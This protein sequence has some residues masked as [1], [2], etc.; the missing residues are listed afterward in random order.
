M[1]G[2]LLLALSA[3]GTSLD[4]AMLS[5]S[6]AG[7]ECKVVATQPLTA[8]GGA[9]PLRHARAQIEQVLSCGADIAVIDLFDTG[10][11]VDDG[12]SELERSR[13]GGLT[14]PAR[15]HDAL[16]RRK[17]VLADVA[18][19]RAT[20]SLLQ[21]KLAAK[22]FRTVGGSGVDFA[23]I[24]GA[25]GEALAERAPPLDEGAESAESPPQAGGSIEWVSYDDGLRQAAASRKPICLTFVTTWCPHCKKLHKV[26]EDPRVVQ[27]ARSF[28]MVQVDADRSKELADRFSPDGSYVPRT[29]FLSS[30]G[31]LDTSLVASQGGRDRYCYNDVDPR[32][33]LGGMDRALA[34]LGR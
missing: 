5:A 3:P 13:W 9:A 14:P 21:V 7:P 2:L 24:E 19:S 23:T 17:T 29:F 22:G 15:L 34:K 8:E 31:R 18:G 16:L 12:I 33:L 1:L 28:V 32:S 25:M 20:A 30:D 26:F 6:E 11:Q 10:S 4:G 27:K